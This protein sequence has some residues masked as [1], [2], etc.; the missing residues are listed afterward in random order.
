MVPSVSSACQPTP[1]ETYAER[2]ARIAVSPAAQAAVDQAPPFT[3]QQL[4]IVRAACNSATARFRERE[5]A[6]VPVVIG[7]G[8][9]CGCEDGQGCIR[10]QEILAKQEWPDY[11]RQGYLHVGQCTRSGGDPCAKALAGRVA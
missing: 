11:R 3:R 5:M 7:D 2:I 8:C 9:P 10:H 6:P 4:D 1:P